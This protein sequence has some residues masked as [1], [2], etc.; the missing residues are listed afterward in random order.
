M[1]RRFGA[2][3]I[4][5]ALTL[6]ILAMPVAANHGSGIVVNDYT[7][8][9]SGADTHV[10]GTMT[11]QTNSRRGGIVVT[12]TYKAAA[13]TVGT[14]T[15]DASFLTNLAPH[16]TSTF[17]VVTPT[18][19]IPGHDNET[20]VATSTSTT[21]QPVGGLEA[22]GTL[23]GDDLSGTVKNE[24]TGT[25]A[26]V[27]VYA[28]RID[29]GNV[30]DTLTITPTTQSLAT[31][32]SSAFA[33]SF[34]AGS[35]GTDVL[36][37][38]QSTSGSYYT[39]WNNYFS[40]LGGS[41]FQTEIAFMADEAITLGCT[42]SGTV[43]YC[44]AS[45]VTREQMAAFLVRAQDLV[46]TTTTDYFTD[47]STS[48]AQAD[49]NNIRDHNITTGCTSATLF[50]PTQTV[51]REQMA[52]F[53]VRAYGVPAATGP[54]HFTDDNSSFAQADINAMYEAGITQGCGGTNFCPKQFVTREQMAAFLYRAELWEAANP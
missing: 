14:D 20:V 21:T 3:L 8:Y 5:L 30:T 51:T 42:V 34:R 35:T 26:D 32:V 43:K 36:I 40:D 15:A 50:C 28:A 9:T 2:A 10:V 39:S 52:S 41:A 18:A 24:S 23:V 48:F 11:N 47:D 44:P 46:R 45:V 6:P 16:A 31:G 25:A 19:S 17:H 38:A 7:V 27:M 12:V 33:G 22:T 54:D 53:I 13:T 29:A 1:I 49:I 37:V 4:G